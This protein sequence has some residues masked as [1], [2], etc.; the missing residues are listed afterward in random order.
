MVHTLNHYSVRCGRRCWEPCAIC[1]SAA[2]DARVH[3]C[4][5][6]KRGERCERDQPSGP[7]YVLDD[8]CSQCDPTWRLYEAKSLFE[9]RRE[10][11]EEQRRGDG[12]DHEL[13]RILTALEA[14]YLEARQKI[15]VTS[16]EIQDHVP[17]LACVDMTQLGLSSRWVGTRCV[18]DDRPSDTGQIQEGQRNE[19]RNN[20]EID[21]SWQAKLGWG[22]VPS[23]RSD[24]FYEETDEEEIHYE[25][26]EEDRLNNRSHE[27]ESKDNDQYSEVDWLEIAELQI[28]EPR[29]Y[30]RAQEPLAKRELD[31]LPSL[32][33]PEMENHGNPKSNEEVVQV[34]TS[35][36]RLQPP[37]TTLLV[38]RNRR[39]GTKS[40]ALSRWEE[41]RLSKSIESL[42]R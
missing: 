35:L 14:G 2:D 24:S 6:G 26:A 41:F 12:P 4:D 25:G 29:S 38:S 27:D 17:F 28:D 36:R 19:P 30:S 8:Y 40:D 11:L 10:E 33:P 23:N 16:P 31:R 9:D 42:R 18:W 32:L 15:M 39:P 3:P 21:T 5:K 20:A 34:M 1:S 22:S 7:E 13:D 37:K